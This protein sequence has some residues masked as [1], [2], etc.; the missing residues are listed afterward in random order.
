MSTVSIQFPDSIAGVF[1]ESGDVGDSILT[2]AVVKWYEL[3]RVSQGKAAEI[4]ELSRSEFLDL[5]TTYRVSAWQYTG[6]EIDEEIAQMDDV[7]DL[8]QMIAAKLYER[9]TLSLG[10]AAELAGVSK[11]DFMGMLGKYAVSIFNYPASDL[12]RDIANAKNYRL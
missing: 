12:D 6:S 3:G 8:K 4:L 5:L 2:A 9:G 1:G 7:D 10:Q 11:R